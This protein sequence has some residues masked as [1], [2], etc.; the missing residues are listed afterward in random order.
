[1]SQT[2]RLIRYLRGKPGSSSLEIIRDLAMTNATGRLSDLR[3]E[4]AGT[5]DELVKTKR[6]DGRW[7]YSI[8]ARQPLTLGLDHVA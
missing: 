7:G 5:D 1:M 6:S 8:Q 2:D 3:D 4:L